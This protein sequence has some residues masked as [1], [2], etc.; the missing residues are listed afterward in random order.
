[1]RRKN[2]DQAHDVIK[3]PRQRDLTEGGELDPKH[4]AHDPEKAALKHGA[5]ISHSAEYR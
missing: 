1:M 4:A 2:G 5:P 3:M